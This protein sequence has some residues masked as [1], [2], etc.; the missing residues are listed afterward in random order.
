MHS[1]LHLLIASS[2]FIS[3]LSGYLR[4]GSCYR[5]LGRTYEAIAAY[6]QVLAYQPADSEALSALNFLRNGYHTS[7]NASSTSGSAGILHQIKSYIQNFNMQDTLTY[8]QRACL[9]IYSRYLSLTPQTRQYIQIGVV[10]VVVYYF[11]F[12]RSSNS[13]SN[14][15]YGGSSWGGGGYG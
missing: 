1:V 15:Y 7:S 12:Y 14:S 3:V 5:S 13:Y 9:N 8:I 10:L 11:F 2:R 4:L 6:E